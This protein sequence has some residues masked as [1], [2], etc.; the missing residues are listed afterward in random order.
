M[1]T[2]LKNLRNA[3]A[4]RSGGRPGPHMGG[5]LAKAKRNLLLFLIYFSSK[6][7]RM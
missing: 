4:A 1:Q 6:I 5:M 7:S 2:L 3:P